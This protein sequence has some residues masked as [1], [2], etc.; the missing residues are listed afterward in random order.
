VSQHPLRVLLLIGAT[1]L[2]AHLVAAELLRKPSGRVVF[3]DATHHF[4]QLRS[5]V[6]D[7]DL[8]FENDYKRIYGLTGGELGT[9]WITDSRTVTGHV[10]NYMP[11]GPAL[12]WLPLYILAVAGQI[13][14]SW[15]GAAP[16]PDGFDRVL[17]MTPGI[18]GVLAATAA[19]MVSWTVVRTRVD[20]TAALV[21]VVAIWLGTHAIYYSLVSPSYSHAASMLATSILLARWLKTRTAPTVARAAQWGALAGLAALMRWQDALFLVIP[22]IEV[23][24]WRAPIRQRAWAGLVLVAAFFAA[25]SPQMAV[26][27]VLYGQP[28]AIPQG[29]AFMQWTSPHPLAVLFSDYHGLFTWAP[30]LLLA[31]A[32]LASVLKREPALRLPVATV[33]M[34]SWYVNAA[35]ADWW[36]GEAFGARRFLSL[37]PIFA[38]GLGAW[39]SPQARSP[40]LIGRRIGLAL[41]VAANLLLL[42]QYQLFMKGLTS[43]APYPAGW[44]DMFVVRL[45]VPFRLLAWWAP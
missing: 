11:V 16:F 24:R 44:F 43:L 27:T 37:F 32:G 33:L 40:R 8:H 3:G 14:L 18:T 17:Q 6:F 23:A 22:L 35:V 26:W 25:F 34:L 5:M 9:E 2:V 30:L 7:R 42:L 38:L 45:A 20:D 10:R 31:V 1:L 15:I 36:A 29:A 19:A 4:V 13:L 39:V 12:L 21:A 41:L 28:L